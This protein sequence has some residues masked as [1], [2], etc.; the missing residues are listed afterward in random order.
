MRAIGY[1]RLPDWQ[2]LMARAGALMPARR[3]MIDKFVAGK[4]PTLEQ[5]PIEKDETWGE[6][7]RAQFT[8]AKYFSKPVKPMQLD[9]TPDLLDTLWGYYFATGSYRPIARL[10][11]M[12]DEGLSWSMIGERLPCT[13]DYI[14][15][16]KRRFVEERMAGLYARHRGRAPGRDAARIEARVLARTQKAP[17]DGSTSPLIRPS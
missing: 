8:L 5:A 11:L 15:R 17:T 14:G 6:K 2:K 9:L 3:P 7:V 16:W 1:S 13:P 4:L 10:I 12:L